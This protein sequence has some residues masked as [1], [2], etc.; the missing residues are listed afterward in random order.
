MNN[1]NNNFGNQIPDNN[2]NT[3]DNQ[4]PAPEPTFQNVPPVQQVNEPIVQI[5]PVET[6][7]IP[8]AE[9]QMNTNNFGQPTAEPKKN[10]KVLLIIIVV[11]VA[12]LVGFAAYFIPKLS[13]DKK[14]DDL[15]DEIEKDIEKESQELSKH[16]EAK[17]YV[18]ADGDILVEVEN[19]N[20]VPVYA[21]VKLVFYDE[22]GG[23]IDTKETFISGIYASKKA[24]GV[25]HLSSDGPKYSK[26]DITVKLS[27]LAYINLYEDKI[28]VTPTMSEDLLLTIQSNANDTIEEIDIGVIYYDSDD[29]I[30]GYSPVYVDALPPNGS[31]VEKSYIPDDSNYDDINYSRYEVVVNSAYTF[32]NP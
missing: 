2:Q 22:N 7:S 26:Y 19:K 32:K 4:V 10:N 30:I 21:N 18:L 3:F 16:Y 11:I 8:Q 27:E 15:I 24:Y 17:D 29:K 5:E 1:E 12:A 20:N 23:L 9:P 13:S 28:S 25:V 14:I 6:K 31:T